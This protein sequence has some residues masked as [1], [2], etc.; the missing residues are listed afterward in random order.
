MV[1]IDP[2]TITP[3]KP[4]IVPRIYTNTTSNLLRSIERLARW[5]LKNDISKAQL[6]RVRTV[7]GLLRL[8]VELARLEFDRERWEK[9]AEIEER[10]QGIEEQLSGNHGNS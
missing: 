4:A 2:E 9:E 1:T 10:L 7:T 6:M 5:T 3:K 8:R